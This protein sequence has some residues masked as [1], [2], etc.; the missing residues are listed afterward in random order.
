MNGRTGC[1]PVKSSFH[2]FNDTRVPIGVPPKKASL[3][4]HCYRW[5]GSEGK[6]LS[7]HRLRTV[8]LQG[9]IVCLSIVVVNLA[10][11]EKVCRNT[12]SAGTRLKVV[13]RKKVSAGEHASR[14]YFL[15]HRRETQ[16]ECDTCEPIR[17]NGCRGKSV[18]AAW[19]PT[20]RLARMAAGV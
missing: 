3:S 8:W 10:P 7:H 15:G 17:V 11:S 9:N 19:F 16:L 6:G 20:R 4:Q 18:I 1:C 13:R 12:V 2:G 5:C 14:C